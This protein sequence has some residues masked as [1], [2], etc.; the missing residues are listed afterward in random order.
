MLQPVITLVLLLALLLSA[1]PGLCTATRDWSEK[2]LGDS[3][4]GSYEG[5]M[6]SAQG[7]LAPGI[8]TEK[9]LYKE[10]L[11]FWSGTFEKSGS[12]LAGGGSPPFVVRMDKDG[13]FT[14][15]A[16]SNVTKETS[17][18]VTVLRGIS[19]E[20]ALVG[21]SGSGMVGILKPAKPGEF[22][23]LC[24]LPVRGVWDLV[25]GGDGFMYAATGPLGQVF[26]INLENGQYEV[27]AQMKDTNIRSLCWSKG[28]LL[29]GGG[30]SGNLYEIRGKERVSTLRHFEEQSIQ[31]I[32]EHR[33]GLLVAVN[34]LRSPADEKA[35]DSYKK[36]FK[37]LSEMPKGFGID[38]KM[39]APPDQMRSIASNYASGAVYLLGRE[40]RLDRLAM[41]EGEHIL[42]ARLDHDNRV[43]LATGPGG[44]V[45]QVLADAAEERE[46]W[47]VQEFEYVNATALLMR[48]GYPRAF[49]ASGH[50]AVIFVRSE[51]HGRSGS[52]RSKVFSPDR[53]ARWGAVSWQGS[54]LRVYTRNGNS[55]KPDSTWTAW[56]ERRNGE[57]SGAATRAYSFAQIRFDLAGKAELHGFTWRFAEKNQRPRISKLAVGEREIAQDGPRRMITWEA[58]DPNSDTLE[59]RVSVREEGSPVWQEISGPLPLA[60]AK[61]AL[62]VGRLPD[63]RYLLRITASDAPSN[64]AGSLSVA[65]VSQPF[66]I[67]NGRPEIRNL[68][69]TPASATLSAMIVDRLSIIS[70]LAISV[71]GGQ[72]RPVAPLDGILDEKEE[73]LRV[74]L[75]TLGP[76]R[77]TVSLRA[78]NA[79][80]N[81][82]V[83][84]QTISLDK[85][86][87]PAPELPVVDEDLPEP[88][89]PVVVEPV[90]QKQP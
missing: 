39:P 87:P 21:F 22:A 59:Y 18:A 67:N 54:G 40:H 10:E 78:V 31:K 68:L 32:L 57:S 8:R 13:S 63:G 38:E 61:F 41:L 90:Q 75:Q 76:G 86:V 42:D 29:A 65:R 20:R 34:K 50:E 19:K 24:K 33:H 53:P 71:D 37:K 80:G 25:E 48:D 3:G 46:L 74:V 49:L 51:K 69:Y 47:T 11:A 85:P 56:S 70:A 16:L 44:R 12:I 35:E 2:K 45:Y 4:S 83:Q 55:A 5:V 89:A 23:T 73:E 9:K 88:T 14:Q 28:R 30:D 15:I 27:W 60:E 7:R 77:H 58:A 81:E 66:V 52:F 62:P 64:F 6:F 72:W 79:A 26:R 1:S 84:Q 82:T 36:Y 43:Y 17:G